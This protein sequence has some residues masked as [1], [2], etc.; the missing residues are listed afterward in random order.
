M[1]PGRCRAADRVHHRGPGTAAGPCGGWRPLRPPPLSR[2]C[3]RPGPAA[4]A[5]APADRTQR[6]P[7][8]HS[9]SAHPGA[10]AGDRHP[11]P[12]AP[13]HP[14]ID[15][16]HHG[17][18]RLRLHHGCRPRLHHRRV[19]GPNGCRSRLPSVRRPRRRR[20]PIP[21]HPNRHHSGGAGFVNH[22]TG[23]RPR[24]GRRHPIRPKIRPEIPR[25]SPRRSPR[26]SRRTGTRP[27]RRVRGGRMR[28]S[29]SEQCTA[30]HGTGRTITRR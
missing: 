12:T 22:P 10:G 23:C 2:R 28:Q 1:R 9:D 26:T 14:K 4:P 19:T 16:G 8:H 20:S 7:R 24:R 18:R 3:G 5:S 21:R 13:F 25:R 15:F 27:G 6:P 17:C 11:G 30:A 29:S